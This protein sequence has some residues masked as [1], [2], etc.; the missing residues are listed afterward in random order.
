MMPGQKYLKKQ[1]A[2][3]AAAAEK[4]IY[5]VSVVAL[6]FLLNIKDMLGAR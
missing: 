4:L 1:D 6:F 5:C 2:N 3:L